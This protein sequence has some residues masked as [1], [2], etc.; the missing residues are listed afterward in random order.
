MDINPQKMN[1]NRQTA[2]INMKKSWEI[3]FSQN[4][5]I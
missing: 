2:A 1:E 4:M 5:K 3:I